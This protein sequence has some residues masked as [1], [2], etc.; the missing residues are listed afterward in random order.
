M[1]DVSF[2]VCVHRHN[3]NVDL[4]VKIVTAMPG[5]TFLSHSMVGGCTESGCLP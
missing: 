3:N 5:Q 1:L 2:R 4:M